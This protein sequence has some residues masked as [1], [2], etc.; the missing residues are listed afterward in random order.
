MWWNSSW[1]KRWC[2]ESATLNITGW[3]TRQ[4][5]QDWKRLVF[6]PIPK[7]GYAKECSNCH[8]IVLI[9]H[10]SKI[11]L[12]TLQVGLE[13]Y[14]N[15]EL[16]DVQAAVRKGRGD[17][18]ANIH[19]IIEK[20]REFQRKIYFCFIDYAKAINC[21]DHNKLWKILKQMGIPDHLTCLLRNLYAGQEATLGTGYGTMDWY[22]IHGLQHARLP[23][24]SPTPRASL[25]SCPLS[26]WCHPTILSSIVPFSS[27]LL[28][29]H[30]ALFQWVSSSHQ[31][32]KVLELQHQSF[33]WIFRAD[34]LEDWLVGSPCSPRDFLKS[35]PIPQFK[36]INPSAL[37]LLSGPTLTFI[38]DSW[39][40]HNFDLDHCQQ[41]NASAF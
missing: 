38:Y 5:P 7:E 20:A 12:K 11:I 33:Q 23:C 36:S 17:Q 34:F 19:W 4:W 14:V 21:V 10:A 29:Q 16:P 22:Q 6:I 13:Y 26:W 30:Q 3:L 32:A 24:P 1:T 15:W 40:N 31:V 2:C 9:S 25:N 35:F 28:S 41:N 18:T 27:C 39:K 37:T 8:I